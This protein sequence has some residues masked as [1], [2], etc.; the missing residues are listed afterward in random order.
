MDL[1]I[2]N[3]FPLLLVG[4]S[5]AGKTFYIRNMLTYKL[6]DERYVPAFIPFTSQ[7]K[8]NQTQVLS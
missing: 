3:N 1:H 6:C 7:T 5:G 2:K 8:G 4:P